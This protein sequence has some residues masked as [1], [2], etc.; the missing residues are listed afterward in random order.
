MHRPPVVGENI[1]GAEDEN[2]ECSRPFGLEANRDHSTC[3]QTDDRDKQTCNA[4]FAL[5]NESQEQEDEQDTASKQ[6][7][8]ASRVS[9]PSKS[10]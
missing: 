6:E 5:D 3:A 9:I 2:Q 7:A 8:V 1:E 4:P 10:I